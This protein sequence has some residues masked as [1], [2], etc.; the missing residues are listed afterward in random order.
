[1]GALGVLEFGERSNTSAL[2]DVK[3]D[4]D[5]DEYHAVYDMN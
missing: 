2:A 1:M 3:V 5:V 4:V